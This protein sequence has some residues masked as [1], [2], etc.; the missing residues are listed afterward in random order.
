[1]D[2]LA[3]C[4]IEKKYAIH[5]EM[6]AAIVLSEAGAAMKDRLIRKEKVSP[7]EAHLMCALTLG[8]HQLFVD[9]EHTDIESLT[10]VISDQIV[11]GEL[12]FPMR[13]GREFYDSFADLFDEGKDVLTMEE[14]MRILDKVSLGVY[15]YGIFVLGPYGIRAGESARSLRFSKRIPGYHCAQQVCRAVHPVRLVTSDEAPINQQRDKL[16]S[17]LEADSEKESDWWGLVNEI[18][19]LTAALYSDQMSSSLA[20]ALGDC[21]SDSELRAVAAR[22]LDATS[23]KL[24]GIVEP[25]LTVR[26][27]SDTV[28]LLTRPQLLQVI[29]LADEETISA[30][31]NFLIR[32]RTIDIPRGEIRRPVVNQGARSGAF[33]LAPELGS[34]GTR[35]IGSDPGFA[36]LREKRL[37]NKLYVRSNETDTEELDWQLRGFEAEDLDERLE[38]FL[39]STDPR[40]ALRRMI[41]ARK[42][43]MVTAC[44]E[45]GIEVGTDLEDDAL[46]ETVLWKLGYEVHY[47]ED[48]HSYFWDLHQRISA[49]TSSSRISGIGDSETFR[50]VANTYFTQ[51]EGLLGD[52]L[53]YASWALMSDHTMSLHPFSYDDASD[54]INGLTLLQNAVEEDLGDNFVDYALDRTELDN[55]FKGFSRLADTLDAREADRD[56]LERA[57]SE[58]PDYEGKTSLKTFLFRSRVPFLNLTAGSRKRLL[59]GFRRISQTAAAAYVSQVRNDYSHYR[60]TSPDVEKMVRALQAVQVCVQELESLGMARVLCWPTEVAADSWGRSRHTFRGPRSVEH[61]FARP[62]NYDWMG[63]PSLGE[64]QYLMLSASFAE[65]NEILRFTPRFDSEFS[66]MWADYPRPRKATGDA[67]ANPTEKATSLDQV[68][69]GTSS[70]D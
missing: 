52:S 5:D 45:V 1:M 27:A 56:T 23:G 24:R 13:Y 50:G 14:T 35:F 59:E 54:R 37:L 53:A 47:E 30:A 70:T 9:I 28:E 61:L 16:R 44:H 21:L 7:K 11:A 43:N 49:L 36:F 15:Q 51:L 6:N 38:D 26:K 20:T 33:G 66:R 17:I 4:I 64:P 10:Q 58:L 62:S 65:P 29:L 31:V 41:L 39:L 46:V 68:E 55:L 63:L 18:R 48:P 3:D 8:H 22:L 57:E 32:D 12:Y 34:L 60:R 2:I 69:V 19:G 67:A 40:A 25:F 42:T